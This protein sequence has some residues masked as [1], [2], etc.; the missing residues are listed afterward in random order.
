MKDMDIFKGLRV[1]PLGSEFFLAHSFAQPFLCFL[2][3]LFRSAVTQPKGGKLSSSLNAGTSSAQ[4]SPATATPTVSSPQ[5]S[6]PDTTATCS[7]QS[8]FAGKT[9]V[10]Q[11]CCVGQNNNLYSSLITHILIYSS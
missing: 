11:V 3:L 10:A 1:S 8:Q 6:P 9:A 5:A 4:T 2:F 7:K